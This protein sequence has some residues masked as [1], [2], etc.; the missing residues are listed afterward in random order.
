M[1]TTNRPPNPWRFCP[2]VVL[3]GDRE[4]EK[5]LEAIEVHLSAGRQASHTHNNI[6]M[7]QSGTCWTSWTWS[8]WNGI[9]DG[10]AMHA[11]A[12]TTRWENASYSL[13]LS[14]NREDDIQ[15]KDLP[16]Y[17]LQRKTTVVTRTNCDDRWCPTVPAILRTILYTLRIPEQQKYSSHGN[18]NA[19]GLAYVLTSTTKRTIISDLYVFSN[20]TVVTNVDL[21]TTVL[22]CTTAV[23]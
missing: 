15:I 16:M 10:L 2:L 3:V 17:V 11:G 13:A 19:R 4:S 9:L 7:L 1:F 8:T 20:V 23:K 18:K 22:R 6:I 5:T 21:F 12:S 14:R